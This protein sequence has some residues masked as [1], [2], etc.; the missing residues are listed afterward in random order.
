MKG[1]LPDAFKVDIGI[2]VVAGVDDDGSLFDFYE[3][4][5]HARQMIRQNSREVYLV[6]DHTKFGRAAHARGGKIDQATTIFCDRTPPAAIIAL[7]E[8]ARA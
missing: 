6:F 1:G 2:C 4:A 3:E 5:V 8:K 7:I